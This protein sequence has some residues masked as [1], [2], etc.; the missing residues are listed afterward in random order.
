MQSKLREKEVYCSVNIDFY[1]R[2]ELIKERGKR[3]NA[4][5]KRLYPHTR[6]E[7]EVKGKLGTPQKKDFIPI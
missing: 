3:E 1:L 4:Q 6:R 7:P 2:S 5:S